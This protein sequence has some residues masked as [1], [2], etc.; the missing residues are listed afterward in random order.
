VGEGRLVFLV[1]L[2]SRFGSYFSRRGFFLLFWRANGADRLVYRW[3]KL[4]ESCVLIH[5]LGWFGPFGRIVHSVVKYSG[6]VFRR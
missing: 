5:F 6:S 3:L 4:D 2:L 1:W